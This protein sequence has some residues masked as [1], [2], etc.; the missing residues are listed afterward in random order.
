[1]CSQTAF[2]TSTPGR[3]STSCPC[4]CRPIQSSHS[5]KAFS[6]GACHPSQSQPKRATATGPAR[7]FQVQGSTCPLQQPKK[8]QPSFGTKPENMAM[9]PASDA[10]SPADADEFGQPLTATWLKPCQWGMQVVVTTG[11][12]AST[13]TK[14]IG[15]LMEPCTLLGV[16]AARAFVAAAMSPASTLLAH[17]FLGLFWGSMWV[18]AGSSAMFF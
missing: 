18:L 5:N 9:S 4:P 8:Q 14:C 11:R 7:P 6:T 2:P 1:M 15:I 13:S 3:P 12:S 16:T 17:F 10:T